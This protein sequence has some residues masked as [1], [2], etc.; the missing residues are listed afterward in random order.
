MVALA[1]IIGQ[2]PSPS[3]MAALT[4]GNIPSHINSYERLFIWAAQCMH[5]IANGDE[6]N[7]VA[8]AGNQPTVQVQLAVTADNVDRFVVT[9]YL[10]V[11]V[12]ALNSSTEKT[13]MAAKDIA[14]AQPHANLLTN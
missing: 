11:D 4:L 12:P 14:T 6:T 3:P 10:P 8:G 9:A 5:S 2:E 13:W 7:V 1:F